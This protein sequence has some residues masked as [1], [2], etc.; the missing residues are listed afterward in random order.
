MDDLLRGCLFSHSHAIRTVGKQVKHF[1]IRI[2]PSK[3][4]PHISSRFDA[5]LLFTRVSVVVLLRYIGD[6]YTLLC[7][8]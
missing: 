1:I 4:R 3:K 5:L 6:I 2:L 7:A 8:T